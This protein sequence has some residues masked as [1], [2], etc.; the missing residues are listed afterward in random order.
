MVMPAPVPPKLLRTR[1]ELT[2]ATEVSAPVVPAQPWRPS[3]FLHDAYR[4]KDRMMAGEQPSPSAPPSPGPHPPATHDPARPPGYRLDIVQFA[5]DDQLPLPS[6]L[7]LDGEVTERPVPAVVS[8][9][10]RRVLGVDTS[11]VTV[12]RGPGV[13]RAAAAFGA[14][15]F[16]TDGVPHVPDTMGTLDDGPGAA[17]LAHELTHV[18]QQRLPGVADAPQMESDAVEVEHW[19]SG[20]APEPAPVWVADEEVT[21]YVE[22]VLDHPS[23]SPTAFD[24]A[25][26]P[27]AEVPDFPAGQ[28]WGAAPDPVAGLVTHPAADPDWV[29]DPTPGAIDVAG[30]HDE[31]ADPA[32]DTVVG[33]LGWLEG[34]AVDPAGGGVAETAGFEPGLV[35]GSVVGPAAGS[36]VAGPAGSVSELVPD[37]VTDPVVGGGVAG[38]AG[39]AS[40]LVAGSVTDPAAGGGGV[41]GSVSGLIPDP[42]TDSVVGGGVAGSVGPVPGLVP[43][44]VTGT[45]TGHGPGFEFGG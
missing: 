4:T 14:R 31:G 24:P 25:A 3:S 45:G 18:V 30:E 37:P 8:A 16:T 26:D 40:G 33:V 34:S 7:V 28:T 20:T 29:P 9:K 21:V 39:F 22:E 35:A 42:V 44:S 43:E 10:L 6:E 1:T 11:G 27:A 17:A 15:G 2:S 13:D 5:R 36:G 38:A 12:R 23:P 19:F 32:A 41:V